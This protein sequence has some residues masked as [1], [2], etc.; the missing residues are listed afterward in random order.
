MSLKLRNVVVDFTLND[1]VVSS[2]FAF[3]VKDME[4]AQK[5][6][7]NYVGTA[8]DAAIYAPGLDAEY[9]KKVNREVSYS[10]ALSSIYR[11]LNSLDN[12]IKI[13]DKDPNK[14]KAIYEKGIIK[15]L[16]ER[17]EAV[18]PQILAQEYPETAAKFD[19]NILK[20]QLK[21]NAHLVQFD[22]DLKKRLSDITNHAQVFV[23]AVKEI[24]PNFQA[25]TMQHMA[26]FTSKVD[27]KM[28]GKKVVMGE[29][30]DQEIIDDVK[31]TIGFLIK[32]DSQCPVKVDHQR[33]VMDLAKKLAPLGMQAEVVPVKEE[34][35][36]EEAVRQAKTSILRSVW[37]GY[38]DRQSPYSCS[39]TLQY[40]LNH[41]APSNYNEKQYELEKNE[42][43]QLCEEVPEFSSFKGD[44]KRALVN[45]GFPPEKVE[46]LT[47]ADI[48]FLINESRQADSAKVKKWIENNNVIDGVKTGSRGG[49]RA[50]YLRNYHKKHG[51][52]LKT[53]FTLRG[54]SEEE[55]N[56]ALML[57][58]DGKSN[59]KVDIKYVENVLAAQNVSKEDIGKT[60]AVMREG[61]KNN[62]DYNIDD[63]KKVL[64]APEITPT[65]T[66]VISGMYEDRCKVSYNAHHY[67]AI[68]DPDT[69]CRVTGKKWWQMNEPSNIVLMDKKTHDLLHSTE[70]NVKGNGQMM[71]REDS[72]TS[73][74]TIFQDTESQKKFY[75]AIRVKEGIEGLMGLHRETI[76]DPEY[77]MKLP[78]QEKENQQPLET[79]NKLE[80]NNAAKVTAEQAKNETPAPSQAEKAAKLEPQNNIQKARQHI[81]SKKADF[82]KRKEMFAL[83]GTKS[84]PDNEKPQPRK[85][86]NQFNGRPNYQGRGGH[87]GTKNLGDRQ[88]R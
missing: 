48:A 44:L 47:Y 50:K 76:Y 27:D 6:R 13:S 51:K 43:W 8:S 45:R 33:A 67:F 42:I 49:K 16:K 52:D 59:D 31:E 5:A 71:D 15:L 20:V 46:D 78:V 39:K 4:I 70:N 75:I 14:Q 10:F 35:T 58:Q 40:V 55:R 77:L 9:L 25:K 53:I 18:Y 60:V 72:T 79:E 87:G 28:A 11:S 12:K 82:A 56:K 62:E 37:N 7:E 64:D 1:G 63:L 86:K 38:I 84:L 41:P 26:D 22:E 29:K 73:Y 36:Q 32:D 23:A 34:T 88:G 3:K 57:M 83:E 17:I 80:E 81:E 69:F 2:G 54:A 74:R 85:Q 65:V 68:N 24:S 61:K 66:N 30:S 19:N 21:G